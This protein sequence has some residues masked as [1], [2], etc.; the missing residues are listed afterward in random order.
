MCGRYQLNATWDTI[1][2]LL[3]VDRPL[4]AAPPQL[5]RFNIAPTQ[6]MVI[7]GQAVNGGRGV[8]VARWGFPALWLRRRGKDPWRGPPLINAKAEEAAKKPT[9]RESLAARRCLI[10]STGFYEWVQ[11]AGGR[12][13]LWLRPAA[14]PLLV[15]AGLWGSFDRDGDRVVCATVLTTAPSSDMDGVH[16]RQPLV[17]PAAA[18]GAWLDPTTSQDQVGALLAPPAAG[19]LDAVPVSTA[20]NR[21]QA[22]GPG[23]LEAD[24][25]WTPS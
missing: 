24:W 6:D 25:T 13:P 11:R 1:V 21:W 20:L 18:W 15:M 22:K 12:Y 7:V 3:A 4:P 19:L 10:P 17:V 23:V 8:A 16:D 14:G 2:G 5:P 9:W